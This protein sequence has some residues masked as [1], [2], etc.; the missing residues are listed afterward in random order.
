MVKSDF[1][2]FFDI[3]WKT[4]LNHHFSSNFQSQT[5]PS[6]P[7]ML[8][9]VP[10]IEK[11]NWKKINF[12]DKILVYSQ[13]FVIFDHLGYEFDHGTHLELKISL[14]SSFWLSNMSIA[15]VG[16]SVRPG[17]AGE[18]LIRLIS[19]MCR[20]RL[21]STFLQKNWFL[22]NDLLNFRSKNWY[23]SLCF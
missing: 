7:R 16:W 19:I 2:I 12:F 13:C 1:Y 6:S 14:G 17:Q 21:I 9:E 10:W 18:G 5:A 23:W 20:V 15:P 4:P 22:S 11:K 8:P 3:F